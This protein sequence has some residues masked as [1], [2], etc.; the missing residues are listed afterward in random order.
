MKALFPTLVLLAAALLIAPWATASRQLADV[1]ATV[2]AP[3]ISLQA[4]VGETVSVVYL[5]YS[6]AGA[7]G[8]AS[9][10][11]LSADENGLMLQ[12]YNLRRFVPMHAILYVSEMK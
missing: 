11:L 6:T 10:T 1:P 2:S 4:L 12:A 9:G 8:S 5:K 3:S 7:S